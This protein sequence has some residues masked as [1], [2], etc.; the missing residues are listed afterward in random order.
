MTEDPI[1]AD[2]EQQLI[3]MGIGLQT[4]RHIQQET[5]GA[6]RRRELIRLGG[7]LHGG[8]YQHEI[9]GLLPTEQGE[10]VKLAEEIASYA[11]EVLASG[12]PHVNIVDFGAGGAKTMRE[13]AV[14]MDEEIKAGKVRITATN[15]HGLPDI[16]RQPESD[17]SGPLAPIRDRTVVFE[18]S[19]ILELHRKMRSDPV[20]LLFMMNTFSSTD[21]YNDAVLKIAANILHPQ[22]GTA[23]FGFG[24][25]LTQ[26]PL[27]LDD[28]GKT[29]HDL[30]D[31]GLTALEERG[32]R[33]R[34]PITKHATR[35]TRRLYRIHQASQA[36]NFHFYKPQ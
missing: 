21:F 35:F 11:R 22:K 17:Y 12:E 10:R 24:G 18:Q 6:R 16:E 31:D 7:D 20:H 26:Q 3:A 29:T 13:A 9:D 36:P 23:V 34:D 19:D 30:I 15:L 14:L 33:G 32:F 5:I 4:I 8:D 2:Q 27:L 25:M 1:P 28:T